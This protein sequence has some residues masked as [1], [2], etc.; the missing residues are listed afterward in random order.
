MNISAILIAK[1]EEKVLER[2]LRSLGGLDDI[3]VYDTGSTDQTV[4]IA[5]SLGANTVRGV[6]DNPFHFA[7]ARNR[8]LLY[9]RHDWIL[10]I[11]ADETLREGSIG[12]LFNATKGSADCLLVRHD[13][14]AHEE[15]QSIWRTWKKRVF[16]KSRWKWKYRV[17]ERPVPKGPVSETVFRVEGCILDHFPEGD[18]PE[19]RSQ[20]MDLLK[21]TVEEEPDFSFAWYALAM[22]YVIQEKWS[23]AIPWLERHLKNPERGIHSSECVTLMHLGQCQARVGELEIAKECFKQAHFKAPDR[24]E[25]LYWAATELLRAA[26][27]WESIWW[28][29]QCLKI[30][31]SENLEFPLHLAELQGNLVQETLD[32]CRA[33]LEDA[34][35]SWKA[36]QKA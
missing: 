24:R 25:P 10:S 20:N 29:E 30:A 8:A 5:K 15:S 6:S 32:G 27:P 21:I 26:K 4:E 11:D 3:V 36:G 35:N 14:R 7:N 22:E 28:L 19:R 1:N 23:E 2:C 16:R 31:P 9:A 33:I 12:P 13:N 17:H 34:E 18:R